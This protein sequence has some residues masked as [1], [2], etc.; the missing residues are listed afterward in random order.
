[1]ETAAL[2]EVRDAIKDFR[3]LRPLRL[4]HL[5]LHEG[6]SIALL[7]FD[8]AMAEVLVNL[9]TGAILPDSGTI[10]VFGQ[11]TNAI[12]DVESW[13]RTLDQFGLIS[14]RAVMLDQLTAEQNLA[15]PLSLH[16]E[17]MPSDVRERV[18][19][20]A[21]E[22]GMSTAELTSPVSALDA[23]GRQR[24]RLGRAL[25]LDPR[26]LLAEHPNA[27]LSEPNTRLFADVFRQVVANR[28]IASLVLTANG[29]F[30]GT[31]SSQVLTLQ[32]ATG[33][34]KRASAL[35]RWLS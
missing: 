2:I 10:S 30:A 32:A 12:P 13:V 34:L 24:L 27:P 14:E 1:V 28:R 31:I 7:G 4:Q 15:M 8:Q 33:A 26:V 16:I 23:L 3:G 18:R 5:D 25:A 22:V 9:L 6:E 29:G 19:G 35:R 20:L 17:T 21:D 11:L